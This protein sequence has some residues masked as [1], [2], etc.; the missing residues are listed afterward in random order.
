MT[1]KVMSVQVSIAPLLC[2]DSEIL[3]DYLNCW[4]RYMRMLQMSRKHQIKSGTFF[5]T[6]KWFS[7]APVDKLEIL[8]PSLL[9]EALAF[10]DIAFGDRH[11]QTT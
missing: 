10:V 6:L 7:Q 11:L 2:T 8:H 9:T 1:V 5:K 4:G 3:T